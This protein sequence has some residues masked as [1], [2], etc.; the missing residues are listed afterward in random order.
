MSVPVASAPELREREQG[1]NFPV[2][3]RVLPRRH[4]EDLHALY[5]FARTVDELGD[6]A[7]GDR[8]A[9][10][11]EF[12]ADLARIWTARPPAHPVLQRLRP[13]VVA[14]RLGPEP[15]CRL[16]R[17]NLQDQAVSRYRT[18]EDLLGYCRLSA[19]PVGRLVLGVFDRHGP[20]LAR[21]SDRVC[22]GLQILEHC[23]DVAEDARDGRIYLP[24]DDLARY[25]VAETD[26]LRD[27]ATP[28]LAA[29]IRFEVDR[30]A[31][32]LAEGAP[33]V[34]GLHGWARVCVAGFVA[35]G[36]ATVAA[37]RRT[38]GDVLAHEAVPSRAVTAGRLGA[39]LVTGGSIAGGRR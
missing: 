36:Q 20:E 32:L 13:T 12:E 15:F 1:E 39:L 16:I 24:L 10:L 7:A 37:L 29:L 21:L 26:L 25:D 38:G 14:H 4:R 8:T 35:G 6:S 18:F 31:E 9:Q 23:Q 2:A 5:A 22:S 30:A 11:R 3:L 27:A 28:R 33:I 34:R 17:A 19:D